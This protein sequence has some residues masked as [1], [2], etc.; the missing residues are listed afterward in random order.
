M[1]TRELRAVLRPAWISALVISIDV[2]I[3]G[4]VYFFL[5][6]QNK[7]VICAALL[8]G[9]LASHVFFA[10][11][12]G[13]IRV[14]SSYVRTCLEGTCCP[15]CGYHVAG[16]HAQADGCTECPECGA[17]WRLFAESASAAATA[18]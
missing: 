14:P 1:A 18:S 5:T 6:L 2:A 8:A 4:S 9:L 12:R 17:A 10:V 11:V 16:I 7:M 3:V 13:N 15:C